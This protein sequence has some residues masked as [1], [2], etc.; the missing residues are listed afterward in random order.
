MT[1]YIVTPEILYSKP[2]FLHLRS[3][4]LYSTALFWELNNTHFLMSLEI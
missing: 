2:Q 1:T 4:D 3:G